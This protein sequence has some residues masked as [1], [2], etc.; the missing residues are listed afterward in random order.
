[1]DIP[2]WHALRTRSR[3]EKVVRDQLAQRGVESFLPLM[4]RVSQWRDR[5]KRID[6]PL[7]SGY[8]FARFAGDQRLS[9]VQAPG[10]VE[11]IGSAQGRPEPIPDDEIQAIQQLVL[12]HQPYDA[13]P[14]FEEGMAVEV[15]RGPLIGIK[16]RLI[17]KTNGFRLII[18]IHLIGQ[19]AAVHIDADDIAPVQSAV[20]QAISQ[21]GVGLSVASF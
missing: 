11:V 20:P 4:S 7:F 1:M 16:G 18:S 14:C 6:W 5:K 10:V 21:D 17:T 3:T 9:V 8:C 2:R 12:S 19:G 13:H 15:V